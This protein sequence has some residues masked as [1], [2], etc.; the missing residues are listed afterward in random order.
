MQ[1]RGQRQKRVDR[2]EQDDAGLLRKKGKPH[3]R[4]GGVEPGRPAA[5]RKPSQQ[6]QRERREERH[7]P[8][9]QDLAGDCDVIGHQRHQEGRKQPCAASVEQPAE[10]VHQI[11]RRHAHGGRGE[12]L[13]SVWQ[14]E[15]KANRKNRLEE[16]RVRSEDGEERL[17]ARVVRDRPGL[18]HVD[19]LIAVEAKAVER[20]D[21]KPGRDRED[22]TQRER[23]G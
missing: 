21:A 22:Q 19:G 7:R 5:L 18:P 17:E 20:E 4:A 13:E 11:D 14:A 16:Q 15:P 10:V 23:G 9:E 8:V 2:A 12:P 1:L 3:C 6:D